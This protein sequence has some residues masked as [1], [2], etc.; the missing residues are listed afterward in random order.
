MNR[1]GKRLKLVPDAE[2]YDAWVEDGDDLLVP[3]AGGVPIVDDGIGIEDVEDI[4]HSRQSAEATRESKCLFET[5]VEDPDIGRPLGVE[6]LAA[7]PF[8]SRIG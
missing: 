3:A 1:L 8:S 2:T 7:N 4:H 6:R 5:D